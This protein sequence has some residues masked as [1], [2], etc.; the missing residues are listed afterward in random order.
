MTFCVDKVFVSIYFEQ[1]K[2]TFSNVWVIVPFLE[3]LTVLCR[4]RKENISLC[5]CIGRQ[6]WWLWLSV[7]IRSHCRGSR[8]SKV[9]QMSVSPARLSNHNAYYKGF[10]VPQI[11]FYKTM[12]KKLHLMLS[13]APPTRLNCRIPEIPLYL[14][15]FSGAGT[16]GPPT[17]LLFWM[18]SVSWQLL[19]LRTSSG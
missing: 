6:S 9:V 15:S 5:S 19:V 13:E 1:W 17:P 2:L 8:F 4:I 7:T 11:L 3:F 18:E 10:T 14:F 16:L 12:G